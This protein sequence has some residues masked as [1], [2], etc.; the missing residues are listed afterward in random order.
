MRIA[1]LFGGNSSE[2]DVSIASG[3]QVF[4]ALRKSGHEVI[5]VD[6]AQGPLTAE[7]TERFIRHGVAE[8]PPDRDALSTLSGS[9]TLL[10]EAGGL[11]NCDVV[12]PALHGGIGE[13]GTIQ[14]LLDLAG[15]PYCGSGVLGS[16][17]AMDKDISKRLFTSSGIAT[18]PWRMA[19]A[20]REEVIAEFGLPVVVKANSEG[21]SIG[22]TIVKTADAFEAAVELAFR[23]DREVMIE[24]FVPG[25]EL[26]VGIL[27]GQALEVGEIV[28]L[29]GEVF[30]YQS[31]YQKGGAREIFPAEIPDPVRDEAKRIGVKVFEAL[32]LRDFA[33]VDFRYDPDGNLWVLEANT[34]PGM[35]ATSLLPQSAAAAGIPFP[36]LCDRIVRLAAARQPAS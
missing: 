32:K 19:P 16:A 6:T 31:K 1:V 35:T 34:L 23:F 5:A 33:R 2:R 27:G 3:G 25:R 13:N 12:F 20:D 36:D 28:P 14:A 4:Q 22:L 11:R 24:K 17:A 10:S 26:T 30:D 21:S 15:I 18:A 29:L 7:E 8:A 9:G